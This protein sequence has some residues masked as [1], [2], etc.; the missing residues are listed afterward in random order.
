VPIDSGRGSHLSSGTNAP[1]YTA[2]FSTNGTKTDD[3]HERH[4][5]RIAAAL[6]IDR[7]HRVLAF[8]EFLTFPRC[9][10]KVRDRPSKDAFPTV[11]TGT[12]WHNDVIDRSNILPLPFASTAALI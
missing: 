6:K 7:I 11:W 2:I 8:K 9:R 10:G 5:A 4:E 3:E 1:L 12:E